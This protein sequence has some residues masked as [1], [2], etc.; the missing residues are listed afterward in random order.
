MTARHWLVAGGVVV[1][2]LALGV[3]A[4]VGG[5][6]LLVKRQVDIRD[7]E[8]AESFE[9][10]A[11]AVL[12]RLGD[13]PP[14]VEDTSSGPRLSPGTLERRKVEANGRVPT[15]LHVLVWAP[16]EGK[17]VRLSL[18]FWLLR[19]APNQVVK[20]DVDDVDLDQLKLSVEDL[21]RAGPG[22]VLIRDS[23]N[24]RVLVWTE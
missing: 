18:P 10:E 6:F 13:A 22:P 21:E 20:V 17:I 11:A 24:S 3:T 15:A 2:V 23:R 12:S 1:L 19:L 8:T 14:L 4:T 5:C 16:D 7:G 9:R